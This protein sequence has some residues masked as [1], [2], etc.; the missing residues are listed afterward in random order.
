[1]GKNFKYWIFKVLLVNGWQ[2]F[3][4]SHKCLP[5]RMGKNKEAL[6]WRFLHVGFYIFQPF[7][8]KRTKIMQLSLSIHNSCK[9]ESLF[10]LCVC[11]FVLDQFVI[12][13]SR[14]LTRKM[15][16]VTIRVSILSNCSEIT[17]YR[18]YFK[19]IKEHEPS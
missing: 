16:F 6:C 3:H 12:T 19:G 15:L 8:C 17:Q 4:I 13:L 5:L 7:G 11:Q 1:M 2:I 14:F 18:V 10:C 9:Y